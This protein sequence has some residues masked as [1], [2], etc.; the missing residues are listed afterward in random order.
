MS[1]FL[2]IINL[3]NWL[4]LFFTYRVV[5]YF[6]IINFLKC[7]ASSHILLQMRSGY[8]KL[9]EDKD[10][11][12]LSFD[13]SVLVLHIKTPISTIWFLKY[14]WVTRKKLRHSTN[15]GC[16]S[17]YLDYM[18]VRQLVESSLS[19]SHDSQDRWNYSCLFL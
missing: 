8:W 1:F 5:T 6:Y 12:R 2:F 15:L 18:A 3:F 10:S 9:I 16:F 13:F 17:A 14:N 11:P 19:S 4:M 7:N